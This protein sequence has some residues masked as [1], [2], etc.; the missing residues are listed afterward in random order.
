MPNCTH[1]EHGL[2]MMD[3]WNPKCQE[4]QKK[5]I[6]KIIAV[7]WQTVLAHKQYAEMCEEIEQRCRI[8][9]NNLSWIEDHLFDLQKYWNDIVQHLKDAFE[10][11][12]FIKNW[13]ESFDNIHP[14]LSDVLSSAEKRV[15]NNESKHGVG[16]EQEY[17]M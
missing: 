2:N 8:I 13:V 3:F 16:K 6:E 10:N 15:Q 4:C 1:C 17:L 14:P 9:D 5:E 11:L 7:I 12:L